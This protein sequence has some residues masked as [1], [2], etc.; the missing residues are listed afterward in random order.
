MAVD[1][2]Y[3]PVPGTAVT[4]SDAGAGG[5]FSSSTVVTDASGKANTSYVTS[6][7]A[8]RIKITAAASGAKSAVFTETVTSP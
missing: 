3:I 5:S 1:I 4:F 7:K 6:S 8:A 2:N